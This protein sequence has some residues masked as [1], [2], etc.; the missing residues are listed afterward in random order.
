MPLNIEHVTVIGSGNVAVFFAKLFHLHGLKI[1]S[2]VARNKVNG[3]HLAQQVNASYSYQ[4]PIFNE[5]ELVLIC[6]KDDAIASISD[7]I[8]GGLVCHT[9]GASSIDLLKKHQNFGVIYPFQSILVNSVVENINFPL[10]IEGNSSQILNAISKF[11]EAI[12]AQIVPVTSDNRLKYHLSAVFA[13]NFTNAMLLAAQKI[14]NEHQ[15]DFNYLQP[16]ITQSIQ[17]ALS[18]GPRNSQ[19]GPAKRQDIMTMNSHLHLLKNNE[20]LYELYKVMS[21]FI[22]KE[23]NA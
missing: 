8:N 6:V 18:F 17:Q 20:A 5:N 12:P 19:T 21:E 4:M 2:I 23:F 14:C 13:N 3:N 7:T 15:L 16:L 11:L 22:N 10:F 9:S 1:K